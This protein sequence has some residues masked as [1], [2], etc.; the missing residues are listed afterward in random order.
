MIPCKDEGYSQLLNRDAPLP[1]SMPRQ[2]H[3]DIAGR[4]AN[5]ATRTV[6]KKHV[7]KTA[8]A[9]KNSRPAATCRGAMA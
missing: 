5:G 8:L 9:W 7:P 1:Y 4:Q 2:G 6:K 3:S